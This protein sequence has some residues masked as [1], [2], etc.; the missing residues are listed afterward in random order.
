MFDR[1]REDG[2]AVLRGARDEALR[3]GHDW[4]GTEHLLLGIVRTHACAAHR[5]LGELG[6]EAEGLRAAM[7][8]VVRPGPPGAP[9]AE[10][11]RQLPFT[12]N[13]KGALEGAWA[14]SR[15]LGHSHLTTGH[16]LLGLLRL[17]ESRAG[18]V[19]AEL[20]IDLG[21]VRRRVAGAAGEGE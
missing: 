16:L 10:P 4:I 20:G 14:E 13:A 5:L 18:R 15:T 2:R 21:V 11:P 19:L 3:L 8:G 1:L 7:E 12:P 17:P 6:L 9:E